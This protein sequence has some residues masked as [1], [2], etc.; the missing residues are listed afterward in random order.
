MQSRKLDAVDPF[1]LSVYFASLTEHCLG[2]G[3][4]TNG[5]DIHEAHH[6]I[7]QAGS[8]SQE[9]QAAHISRLEDN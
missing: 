8:K 1:R 9:I 6:Y 7:V 4:I 3:V 2:L 5:L